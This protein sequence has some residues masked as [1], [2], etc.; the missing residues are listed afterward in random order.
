MNRV[1]RRRI[2]CRLLRASRSDAMKVAVGFSPR[3]NVAES[4]ASRSDA[5]SSAAVGPGVETPGYH[6]SPLCGFPCTP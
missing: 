2:S 5:S 3:I 6:H 1:T 4:S